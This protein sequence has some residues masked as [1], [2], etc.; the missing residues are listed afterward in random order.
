MVTHPN[1]DRLRARVLWLLAKAQMK[2]GVTEARIPNLVLMNSLELAD[3]SSG[4][5]AVLA[6]LPDGVS[7]ERD[8]ES[9]VL[10]VAL[11]RDAVLEVANYWR[12]RTGRDRRT[13]F[14]A[15]RLTLIRSRLRSGRT[16][17]ELKRAVDACMNSAWHKG[18]NPQGVAYTDCDHI[19]QPEKLDRWLSQK[20]APASGPT[21]AQDDATTQT[22]LRRQSGRY[23]R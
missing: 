17:E 7:V 6:Y 9:V 18:D 21:Q 13:E 2:E 14:T 20:P 19:F 1:M 5:D 23:G 4:L 11:N 16:V 22:I 15:K 12:D 10:R 3:T 8:K